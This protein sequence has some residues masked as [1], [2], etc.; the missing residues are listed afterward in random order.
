MPTTTEWITRKDAAVL[1]R[2]SQDAIKA[3]A[4]KHQ[5]EQ[6]TNAG[7][8]IE[9]RLGDL[10]AVGRIQAEDL[11]GAPTPGQCVELVRARGQVTELLAEVARQGG[12]LAER[13][14]LLDVLRQQLGE[15]DR[16]I[17]AQQNLLE[18]L[19]LAQGGGPR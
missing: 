1:A 3:T 13:D 17:K 16:Q 8:A 12:R 2:C 6:R 14:M 9:M 5:L 11:A 18:R 10:V 7:G 4:A 19:A 15:K